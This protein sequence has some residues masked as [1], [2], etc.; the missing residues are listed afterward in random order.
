MPECN[1]N[2]AQLVVYLSVSP[3]SNAL[4]KAYEKVKKDALA[5]THL[6]V[7][8]HLRNAETKLDKELGYGKGYRYAHDFCSGVTDMVCLPK[9]LE[10][11]KYYEPTNHGN[12]KNIK[13]VM[14]KI[15]ETKKQEK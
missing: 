5:T 10:N 9:E 2:I 6:K 15:E 14:K 7:P 8:L 13:E 4:Y 1:V 11:R 3:K 12:E